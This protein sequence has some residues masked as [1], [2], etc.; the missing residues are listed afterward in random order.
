MSFIWL[1][2]D[3]A[4]NPSSPSQEFDVTW[5]PFDPQIQQLFT[6]NE[7]S[8]SRKSKIKFK[9]NQTEF[10]A[11]MDRMTQRNIT[12]GFS[13]RITVFL[14]DKK[15][16]GLCINWRWFDVNNNC[17]ISYPANL[18][19]QIEVNFQKF[20][21]FRQFKELVL[22]ISNKDQITVDFEN[23]SARRNKIST[24]VKR[25][26]ISDMTNKIKEESHEIDTKH[27][28]KAEPLISDENEVTT[29]P[30]RSLRKRKA[31]PV[32]YEANGSDGEIEK[33]NFETLH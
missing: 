4:L 24:K 26:V 25:E 21:K 23:M 5:R 29:M 16:Y 18:T 11:D 12:T 33:V 19:S 10:E 17:W 1:W 8:K 14:S 9:I 7:I 27:R 2:R 32:Y 13:R 15:L 30:V 3:T 6:N 22:K 20:T 28:I 31:A